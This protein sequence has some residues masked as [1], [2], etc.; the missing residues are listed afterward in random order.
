MPDIDSTKTLLEYATH[1]YFKESRGTWVFRGHSDIAYKLTPSVGRS[2]HTSPS[3]PKYERGLFDIFRREAYGCLPTVPTEDWELLA[4]AQHHGLPTRL[5]DW[6]Y[7]LLVAL[8]FAV[9]ADARVDGEVIALR[10]RSKPSSVRTKSPFDLV[11]PIKYYPNI[12][13]PRIRAQEGLFVACVAPAVALDQ[14]LD[15][16][17]KIDRLRVPFDRKASLRY[18]LFRLGIH[19]SSLFPDINGLAARIRWQHSI[20]SPFREIS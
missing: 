6:T 2:Q 14:P 12:V 5:L 1:S 16:P 19:A 20:S 18:E 17:W 13:T 4:L 10:A 15:R 3:F 11:S 9:E 8:Y 7:N